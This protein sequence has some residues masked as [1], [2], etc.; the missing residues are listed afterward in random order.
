MITNTAETAPAAGRE[1]KIVGNDALPGEN[2]TAADLD[3]WAMVRMAKEKLPAQKPDAQVEA[4]QLII[5]LDRA[6]RLVS[7]DIEE[8]VHRP[9]GH[10][11]AVFRYLFALWMYGDLPSHQL[12]TV[13]GMRRSQ[14]SNLAGSLEREGLV[15]RRKS[16]TDGRAVVIS[17]SE[18]GLAYISKVFEDHHAAEVEWAE[19]L[20]EIER[21][22]L[23][24]L[25]DKLM[26][27]PKG[28]QA[29]ANIL[30]R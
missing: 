25:L 29:R 8:A 13:T 17:L 4:N 1:R 9:E 15:N 21:D 22:V 7:S 19:G 30:D 26:Q 20:T 6:S 16:S 12:A 3:F 18:E 27:S 11:W 24:A 10:S 23:I 14:V 5:S 28:R 2:I